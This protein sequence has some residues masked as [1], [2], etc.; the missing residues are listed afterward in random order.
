MKPA[1]LLVDLQSDF[2][3]APG[4]E[5]PAGEL[6]ERAAELLRGCR[7]M[8]VPVV[9]VWTTIDREADNRM[10]HWRRAGR[11]SCVAGTEGHATPAALSPGAGEPVVDKTSFSGFSNPRLAEQLE[12]LG[13]EDLVVCGV[14][15]HGCVRR[16]VLDAYQRGYRV[17]VPEDAV[18]SYDGLHAAV[19]RRYL[20]ARAARF[21][22]VEA[23]LDRLRDPD[24]AA[25]APSSDGV[26]QAV[27]AAEGAGRAW[28]AR[29]DVAP[30][31]FLGRAADAIEAAGEELAMQIVVEI[32]KPLR[33]ARAEV[34]RGA[35]LLRVAA[36]LADPPT[37]QAGDAAIRRVPLGTVAQI[38][39][40]N[41]PLAVPLGKLA[42]ALRYGTT[43]VW[44]PSPAGLGVA[45]R[46]V[47]LLRSAGMRPGVVSLLAGGADTA[48]A[49]M[50]DPAVDAVS[51][52]GSSR[53]GFAAQAICAARRIPLQA[54]LG[55]NNAAI[56]WNDCD[57][58]AAAAAIAEAGFGAAG[59]R[60]TANRRVIVADDRHAEFVG[61]LEA[62]S[63][64]LEVG[65]PA[66]PGVHVGPLVSPAAR[67][68]V[69][70]AVARA[71][72]EFE[73][74][75]PV[76]DRDVVL[77]LTKTG[78]YHAPTLVLCDDQDAEIV[79]EESFGPV[80]VVQ[81]A[82]T[83]EQAL[84]R[85]NGVRQGLVASLF[86]ASG[87]LRERF[88]EQAQAGVLK[89]DRATADVGIEAPFGGWK[90]SGVGPPEHGAAD[91]EFYTR[92]QA[93]YR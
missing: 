46:V 80:I 67:D 41:N 40:F 11:W 14:H 56:V 70:G 74:W 72:A 4:L 33:Y 8:S 66:D 77:R 61:E 38:T 52:T 78:P 39:P 55:G 12:R 50:A 22:S 85:L 63:A 6:I 71:R 62:A 15:L 59:Q 47:E 10:P 34:R 16:T 91:L 69:A 35:A 83:F 65:D 84:E 13:T 25:R 19:T 24:C 27:A 17:W 87:E 73:V 3:T 45:E 90:A 48:A 32:G 88:I 43:V 58:A 51:L 42:P 57:L 7:A 28:R 20:E 23:L 37:E 79:Q 64:T 30:E 86:S 68:R 2:L 21:D 93:V 76:R 36:R 5:P 26:R 60:C 29:P 1:L 31:E 18:G 9:H 49:L 53:A 89:L 44:K 54:E 75:E 92:T 82:S 81:R